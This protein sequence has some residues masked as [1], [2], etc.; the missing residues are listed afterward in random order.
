MTLH[1]FDIKA[2]L[3][4]L[5]GK[6]R[7]VP[8][9]RIAPVREWGMSLL[10]SVIGAG[11]LFGYAGYD[12]YT[13]LHDINY[14]IVSEERVPRYRIEEAEALIR[15]YEGREDTFERLRAE[16]PRVVVPQA[17]PASSEPV[18]IA[19]EQSTTE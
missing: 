8:R 6:R 16:R 10:V 2:L 19:E 18:E 11:V 12:F 14:P 1:S 5:T 13:Q 9:P 17:E 7:G 4:V 15:Y 3:G